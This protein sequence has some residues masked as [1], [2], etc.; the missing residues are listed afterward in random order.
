M[1]NSSSNILENFFEPSTCNISTYFSNYSLIIPVY[2]RQYSWQ[3]NEIKNLL[4]DILSGYYRFHQNSSNQE[5]ATFLGSTI[6][7]KDGSKY[8]PYEKPVEPNS[9]IDGQQRLTTL[10][11][12]AICLHKKIRSSFSKIENI[13]LNDNL[14]DAFKQIILNTLSDLKTI[15]IYKKNVNAKD[16]D[17]NAWY[18]RM[19]RKD[20]DNWSTNSSRKYNSPISFFIFDYFQN[21]LINSPENNYDFD[22]AYLNNNKNQKALPSDFS[23]FDA[24][25]NSV[26]KL[27]SDFE[28]LTGE[29]DISG[30]KLDVPAYDNVLKY[31]K[32][33]GY[34]TS[35]QID[36]LLK[37]IDDKGKARVTKLLLST[38]QLC[39]L[40]NYFCN[41]TGFTSI[42]ANDEDCAFAIFE[43]LNT[44]GTPLTPFETFK[45]KV[46]SK[47]KTTQDFSTSEDKKQ[48]DYIENIINDYDAKKK[49]GKVTF[50]TEMLITFSL[51]YSG[52]KCGKK[53]NDLRSYLHIYE[54]IDELIRNN[55][56]QILSYV[57]K[58]KTE[59]WDNLTFFKS[60]SNE[61]YS[62]IKEDISVC[63][64]C[65]KH[66]SSMGHTIVQPILIRYF[67]DYLQN[68]DSSH[69]T[70]FVNVIKACTAFS[71]IWLSAHCNTSG[72]DTFYRA[73]VKSGYK[74]NLLDLSPLSIISKSINTQCAKNDG[75][76]VNTIPN[77][78]SLKSALKLLLKKENLEQQG[79]WI[80][81]IIENPLYTY[82]KDLA[83]L[84]LLL[85][86]NGSCS[87]NNNKGFLCQTKDPSAKILFNSMWERN[88]FATVEHIAPQTP[89]GAWTSNNYKELYPV[90]PKE[91]RIHSI[92]NLTP[93]P[94]ADNSA[95][96]NLSW[97]DKHCIFK[98]LSDPNFSDEDKIRKILPSG[99]KIPKYIEDKLNNKNSESLNSLKSIADVDDS[100]D[101]TKSFIEKRGKNI[102]TRA[103]ENMKEWL[104]L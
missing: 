77:V 45:P 36:E 70:N 46:I 97:Q 8:S 25:I 67:I 74:D 52:D 28:K 63:E 76:T 40:A 94:Q 33:Q 51:L 23:F 16:D 65:I 66:L 59:V 42:I 14:K 75:Y 41:W 50:T 47:Y 13:S 89:D 96:S 68:K 49:N 43:S 9:L 61:K 88:D 84:L 37:I 87:D 79:N 81:T 86:L 78:N 72:I 53:F 12:I 85:A 57:V 58:F 80:K 102:A 100:Q 26:N 92:G 82:N 104:D 83:K 32:D 71:V 10:L 60:L 90:L 93:L 21:H 15:C 39:F 3:D 19:I 30:E 11:I 7:V 101:W 91:S 98:F 69:F 22:S 29:N 99:T 95:V 64:C 27:L 103:W 73:L 2:Q 35:T 48:I 4:G 6:S 24:A 55:F 34:F 38:I 17:I 31:I 54:N 5:T 56:L 1:G 62:G 44:S 18:P 20:T